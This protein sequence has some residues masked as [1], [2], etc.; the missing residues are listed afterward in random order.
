MNPAYV[1]PIIHTSIIIT[2]LLVGGGYLTRR[3]RKI[4]EKLD[5][6]LH[7]ISTDQAKLKGKA[8]VCP[9]IRKS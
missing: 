4:E 9:P 1:E 7:F 8:N 3:Q 6:V 5:F 2:A